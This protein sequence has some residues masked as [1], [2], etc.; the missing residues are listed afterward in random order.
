MSRITDVNEHFTGSEPKY[1]C[2]IS[3]I[4]LVQAL[5]WYSQNRVDK[6]AEKYASDYFKKKLKVNAVDNLIKNSSPTFGFLCRLVSNGAK[7]SEKD[8]QWFDSHIENLKLQSQVKVV[9]EVKETP[10]TSTINIQDRIKEKASECIAELE[11]YIDDLVQSDFKVS[12]N[13]YG[14]MHGMEIK[15]VHVRHISNHFKKKR[16]EYDEV[17]NTTDKD[18]KEGYSNFSKTHLK[19]LVSYFDQIIVDCNKISDESVKSRK[20]R[21]VKKKTPEQL[22]S[23]VKVCEEFVELGLKSI[24]TKDIVGATQLWVYNTKTRKLGVYHA[25]DAGGFTVKGTSLQNYNENKSVQKKLRKPEVTLPEVLKAGK[26]A[27]RSIM[28]DIRAVESLL[29][30]RLNGDTILLRI[31]K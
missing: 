23:K 31:V 11:G 22:V 19:K 4:E 26:V 13:A 29:T 12:L 20:P 17:L 30:G 8:Q 5:N 25:E 15:S 2:E 21:K 14:L 27:I 3:K 18:L 28:P 10:Q 6:D 24:A 9:V 16:I 1:D 7:L